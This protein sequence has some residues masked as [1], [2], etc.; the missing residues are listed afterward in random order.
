MSIHLSIYLFIS[1]C[2]KNKLSVP[3]MWE[4][5]SCYKEACEHTK[6]VRVPFSYWKLCNLRRGCPHMSPCTTHI[7]IPRVGDCA[8]DFHPS[9]FYMFC[10]YSGLV[11]ISE[12]SALQHPC[13]RSVLLVSSCKCH[14]RSV[15]NREIRRF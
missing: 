15:G 4:L 9:S 13:M 14:L 6:Y 10:D 3:Y 8:V 12:T 1:I 2:H 5:F 7:H 11:N